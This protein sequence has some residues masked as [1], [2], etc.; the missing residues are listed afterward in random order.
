MYHRKE[1]LG[2]IKE[3]LRKNYK[4]NIKSVSF[5][6][7]QDHGFEQAPYEEIDAET[8]KKLS[9]AIKKVSSTKVGN[10]HVLEDLECEGGVC[11]I[12]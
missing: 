2:E 9:T 8:Y 3:W 11:P 12:R 1:E 5:L 4:S 10:G 6:L 7:H